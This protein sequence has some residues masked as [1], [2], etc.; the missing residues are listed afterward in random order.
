MNC[1]PR[2]RSAAGLTL[3]EVV[4]GLAL[5]ATILASLL[6]ARVRFARN[7]SIADARLQAVAAADALL[8][9][10]TASGRPIPPSG[11]GAIAGRPLLRW[12]TQ[13]V[14]SDEARRMQAR[15]VRLTIRRADAPPTALPLASVD[16]V[17]PTKVDRGDRT[18]R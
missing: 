4:A 12:Q 18:D 2:R 11:A 9:D 7:L 8:T 1:S 17:E 6:Y 3:I 5:L 15:V 13:P 14:A 16:V 10:W